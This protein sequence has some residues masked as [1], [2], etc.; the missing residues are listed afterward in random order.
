MMARAEKLKGDVSLLFKTCNGMTARMFLVDTLQ[1]LGIDHHFEEQI[2]DSLN[3]ILES[4]FSSSSSLHEVALRFR[5]LRENGHWV[6][7]G[8]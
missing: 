6:S 4:D 8:I 3:E 1:H 2:H 5:L 7:P